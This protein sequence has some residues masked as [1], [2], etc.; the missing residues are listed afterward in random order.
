MMNNMDENA[1][2]RDQEKV[3]V[4]ILNWNGKQDSLNC[5]RSVRALE[6]GNIEIIVVDNG[7]I[8]GS[9]D[10]IHAF[11]PGVRLIATGKN[12]GYAGGNNVG[13]REALAHGANFVLVLNN[14]ATVSPNLIDCFLSASAKEPLAAAFSAKIYY[15]SRPDIIWYAGARWMQRLGRFVHL[16]HGEQD[17]GLTY[18]NLEETDYASGCALFTSARVIKRVGLLDEKYFLMFEEADWCYRARSLGYKIFFVPEAKVWHKVSTSFGGESS[19][20]A[21]YF[22]FRNRLLWSFR[23]LG[24][25]GFLQS[26]RATFREIWADL[27]PEYRCERLNTPKQYYWYLRQWYFR[28]NRGL[29][30]P[31]TRA[32]ILGV[33]DFLMGRF[34]DCD[35]EVRRLRDHLSK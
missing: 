8:D 7:S 32:R 29:Q 13:M 17:D 23:H 16:G 20:L 27:K 15:Q 30:N 18:N 6:Y 26:G 2:H 28:L 19:P 1:C 35:A 3:A 10:A 22:L 33:R 34:G 14:D 9:V 24:V 31:L 4:V 5:I 12:L 21:N 25:R 11:Y